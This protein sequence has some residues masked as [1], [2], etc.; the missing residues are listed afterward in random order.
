MI[1]EASAEKD[2]LIVYYHSE[3]LLQLE[4][5]LHVL[6][7]FRDPLYQRKEELRWRIDTMKKLPL[8][9][10][11]K[12]LRP[13]AKKYNDKRIAETQDDLQKLTH[14]PPVTH[15]ETQIID[16]ALFALYEKRYKCFKLLVNY[17]KGFGLHFKLRRNLL[18]ITLFGRMWDN[19]PDFIFDNRT[20]NV[21]KGIGFQFDVKRNKYF[22]SV[23]ISGF[24]DAKAIK[25]LLSRFFIDYCRIYGSAQNIHLV[26]R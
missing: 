7:V 20:S 12:T 18:I 23:D 14:R 1:R 2:N 21:L 26:Y 9:K 10:Y 16:D 6:Y 19:E 4:S 22:Y 8:S 11:S 17:E 25:Q 5:R 13:F 15:S 3:A 24:K